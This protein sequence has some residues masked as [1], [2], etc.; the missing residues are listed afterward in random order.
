VDDVAA[1]GKGALKE[2]MDEDG[3]PFACG[4]VFA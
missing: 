4:W 3:T 2:N 1:T